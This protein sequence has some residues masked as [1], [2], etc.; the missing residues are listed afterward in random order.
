MK[1]ARFE[2]QGE[3]NDGIIKGDEVVAL[4]GS[5]LESYQETQTR[6]LLSEVRLLSPV[7]PTKIVCVARNYRGL[8]TQIG[9]EF[10]EKP[11]FFLK[12][13]SCLIGHNHPILYPPE[14]RRVI[15]EG[16]LA[17]VIKDEMKNVPQ[18]E[19]LKHV[20]GYSCFNDV[21]ELAI[22]EESQHYLSIGKGFDTFGPLG[23]YVVTDLDPGD[24]E[25]RT[26]LNGELRQHDSTRNCIFAVEY[27]LHYI[28]RVMTL[29]PG[30]VVST[31]TPEGISPM[32]P[33]DVV[34]V[35]IVGIGQLK[36]PVVT[37]VLSRF[38]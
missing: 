13:P 12:P 15:F 30:D 31:G 20:L 8:I 36:N 1:F 22:I 35:D 38:E 14:A 25:I 2:Y 27:I 24:L 7:T 34:E 17:V 37:S 19:T 29:C 16:E 6:H 32:K 10:P 4:E 5:F 23:P 11:V 21:T 26:Y 28:S 33:G 18:E 9:G 3:I